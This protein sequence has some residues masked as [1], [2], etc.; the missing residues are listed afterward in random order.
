VWIVAAVV[1]VLLLV[2]GGPFLYIH[3]FSSEPP[4]A[5]TLDSGAATATTTPSGSSGGATTGTT[6]TT[7][8]AGASSATPATLDGTWNVTDGSQAGYRAEEVLFGQ[9]TEAV[10]RTSAV[11][12]SM[13]IAGTTVPKASFTVDLTKVTSD[14]AQRDS[15]FQGRIM[16]TSDFPTATF[17][18]TQPIELGTLP[19]DGTQ[20]TAKATGT[21]QLHGTSKTVTIDLT[22]ERTG[23]TIKVNGTIPVTFSDYG[24]DNPSGGPAQVGDSGQIEFLIAFTKA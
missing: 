9:S 10:G 23:G 18:L 1:V 12:G 17:T 5:L 4:P 19:G 16:D 6:G 21:L 24:I 20:I 14:K 13:T 7:G 8:A 22:A 15:Q 3:V 11:T 2:V